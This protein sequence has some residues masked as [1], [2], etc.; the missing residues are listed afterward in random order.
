VGAAAG[1]PVGVVSTAAVAQ[2][3]AGALTGA[4]HLLKAAAGSRPGKDFT[5][6]GKGEIDERPGQVPKLWE[7]NRADTKQEGGP[8][9]QQSAAAS[10]VKPKSEG[11]IGTPENGKTRIKR[12]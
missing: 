9:T 11:G 12:R 2:G 1:V 4:V 5:K 8:H 3:G 7:A 6:A 10:P